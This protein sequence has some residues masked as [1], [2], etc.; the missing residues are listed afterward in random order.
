MSEWKVGKVILP[1]LGWTPW[2]PSSVSPPNYVIANGDL[3]RR[4]MELERRVVVLE[5]QLQ[6][7]MVK[8]RKFKNR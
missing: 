4:I 2:S 8:K 3:G 5:E 7:R 6:K 1:S